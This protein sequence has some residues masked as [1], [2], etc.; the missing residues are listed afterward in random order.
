MHTETMEKRT[1]PPGHVSLTIRLIFVL[2]PFFDFVDLPSLE[3]I[4]LKC[5]RFG[6]LEDSTV[7]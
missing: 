7:P 6:P 5:E 2:L 1:T 3:D 4:V